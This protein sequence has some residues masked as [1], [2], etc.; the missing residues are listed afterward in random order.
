MGAGNT[1]LLVLQPLSDMS[2]ADRLHSRTTAF[3]LDV[4]VDA[5]LDG[6][7]EEPP[8]GDVESQLRPPY[9]VK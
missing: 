3:A 7:S 5:I 2:R 1:L 6:E 8:L 4:V 9:S